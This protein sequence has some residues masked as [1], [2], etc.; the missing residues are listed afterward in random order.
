MM[1]HADMHSRDRGQH[2]V[3]VLGGA[4]T[5]VVGLAFAPLVPRDSNPGHVRVTA[6]GVARN[7][8]E[9]LARL[10]VGV[11]LITAFGG[12]RNARD[13]AQQCRDAGIDVSGSLTAADL[14]G[15]VYISIADDRGEMALALSDMRVLE[16]MTPDAIRAR[17]H[18]IDEAELAVVDAN[19][20]AET[21]LWLAEQ[22]RVPLVLDAVSVAKASRVRPVLPR[23]R[24]LKASGLEAGALLG[25]DVRNRDHALEA[26]RELASLGVGQAY[27]TSGAFGVAWADGSESGVLPSPRVDEVR[28]STGAGDAF[29]AGVAYGTLEQWPAPQA[30]AFGSALAA[31]ALES[32][33]SV[34]PNVSREEALARMDALLA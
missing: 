24:A 9:N 32:E 12:D 25:R 27:V 31:L 10:G 33:E 4:N 2:H 30:A 7:I 19:L 22:V 17:S 20:P 21:I 14:P 34:S 18:I 23:L 29:A 26:A 8:A 6:G 3:A 11:H 15:A 28:N 13:L 16:Q 1:A 5:D